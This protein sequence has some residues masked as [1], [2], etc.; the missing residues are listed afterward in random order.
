VNPNDFNVDARAISIAI[1]ALQEKI[2]RCSGKL[3]MEAAQARGDRHAF[4]WTPSASAIDEL[5]DAVIA[6]RDLNLFREYLFEGYDKA[7]KPKEEEVTKR[8][9]AACQSKE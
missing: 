5:N 9:E 2:A 4:G 7:T 8:K 6:L 1:T 3:H